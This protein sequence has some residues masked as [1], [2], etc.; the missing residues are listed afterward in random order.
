MRNPGQDFKEDH[1]EEHETFVWSR[2]ALSGLCSR[3]SVQL[4]KVM[5]S[6]NLVGRGDKAR[7]ETTVINI[8]SFHASEYI[9]PVRVS[10]EV[11]EVLNDY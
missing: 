1:V 7:A 4:S 9:K 2:I 8:C 3:Q 6:H 10:P 11:Q 5:T